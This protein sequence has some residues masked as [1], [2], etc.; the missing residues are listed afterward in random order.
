MRDFK[1]I[2]AGEVEVNEKGGFPHSQKTVVVDYRKATRLLG[3]SPMHL[4]LLD[5]VDLYFQTWSNNNLNK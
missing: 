5:E 2:F 4:P 1:L 3:W